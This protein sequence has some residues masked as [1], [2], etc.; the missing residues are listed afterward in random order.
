[1]SQRPANGGGERGFIM[2]ALLVGMAVTAVWMSALLPTWRQQAQRQREDDLIFRGEQYARAIALFSVKNNGALPTSIDDLVQQRYLRRKW[3][4]PITGKDFM[5]LGSGALSSPGAGTGTSAGTGRG[6]QQGGTPSPQ[7]GSGLMAAGITGVYSE[8]TDTSIR[9]YNNAQQ[10][11][12]WVFTYQGALL[13]MGRIGAGQPRG[14]DGRGG[15]GGRGVESGRG[16]RGVNPGAPRGGGQGNR[17]GAP[18]AGRG[19]APAPP[20]RSGGAGGVGS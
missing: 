2:V 15:T 5:V 4:D 3:K 12:Q 8:S 16:G 11:N 19:A 13:R 6:G 1:M 14:G 7:Q 20:V 9:I 18:P 17:G 10:Y